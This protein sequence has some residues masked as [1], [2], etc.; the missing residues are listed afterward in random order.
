MFSEKNEEENK[1]DLKNACFIIMPISDQDGYKFL[2]LLSEK[3]V[4][5][6]IE[7]MKIKFVIL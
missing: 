7:W 6:R 1:V 2:F 3:L 4:M 5:N